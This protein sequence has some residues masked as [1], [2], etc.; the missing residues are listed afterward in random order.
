L[1]F[2]VVLAA[3]LRGVEE[4]YDLPAETSANLYQLTPEQLL[5]EGISVLPGSLAEALDEM[6]RSDLVADALGEHVFEWFIRNKRAEWQEYKTQV[7][8]FE[9]DRYLPRL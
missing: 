5:A 9:L 7:S 6:E 2:S 1:A 4:G 3:G 8:Q